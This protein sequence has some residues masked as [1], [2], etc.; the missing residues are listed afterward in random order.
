MLEQ[1]SAP[2]ELIAYY[3]GAKRTEQWLLGDGLH[4]RHAAMCREK[5]YLLAAWHRVLEWFQFMGSDWLTD[6]WT[7]AVQQWWRS[8]SESVRNA[9]A[10]RTVKPELP[11]LAEQ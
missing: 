7:G 5:L 9:V 6:H 1:V 2:E 10:D 8:E 3:K 4:R 11:D